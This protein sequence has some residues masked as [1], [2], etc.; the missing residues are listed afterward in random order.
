MFPD[1]KAF[2]A[3]CSCGVHVT[4]NKLFSVKRL[5]VCSALGDEKGHIKWQIVL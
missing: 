2:H 1:V 4:L 3:F 5:S